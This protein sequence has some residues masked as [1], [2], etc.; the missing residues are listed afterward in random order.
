MVDLPVDGVVAEAAV[1]D[2][3]A[4][5]VVAA[6]DAGELPLERNHGAVE[7]AVGT[8]DQVARDDRIVAVAPDRVDAASGFVLPGDIGEGLFVDDLIF[9]GW[10]PFWV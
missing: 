2:H 5:A 1:E 7:D 6:E 4:P 3:A 10:G 8:G 9:H